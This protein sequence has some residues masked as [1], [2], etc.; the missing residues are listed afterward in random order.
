[1]SE[2]TKYTQS[3]PLSLKIKSSTSCALLELKDIIGEQ[4]NDKRRD[5]LDIS[6]WV[7][8]DQRLV[9]WHILMMSILF[10]FISYLLWL[11]LKLHVEIKI[12]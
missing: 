2:Q 10:Y 11:L 5:A 7:Q 1:M 9:T 8:D 6:W 12:I 3:F 4:N